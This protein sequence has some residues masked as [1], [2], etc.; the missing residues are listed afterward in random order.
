M[1]NN[2][3]FDIITNV[4]FVILGILAIIITIRIFAIPSRTYYTV[5]NENNCIVVEER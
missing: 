3:L 2:D 1:K 5:R 4:F